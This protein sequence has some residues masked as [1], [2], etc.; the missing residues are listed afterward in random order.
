MLSQPQEHTAQ[1]SKRVLTPVAID[2]DVGQFDD[3]ED[4]LQSQKIEF[5]RNWKVASAF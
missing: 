3:E 1:M 5:I 4:V 2:L